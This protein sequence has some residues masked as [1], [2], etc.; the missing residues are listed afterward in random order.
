[1]RPAARNAFL[2]FTTPLEGA[3]PFLYCDVLGLV[4]TAIGVLVDPID[5]ALTL[6][7]RRMP[8]GELA[9]RDEIAADW[10]RVKARTDLSHRGGMVYAQIAQLRLDKDGVRT[11]TDRKLDAMLHRLRLRFDQWDTWPADAQLA[12]VSLS[13]A[14]GPAF[15]FPKLAAHLRTQDWRAAADECVIRPDHGTIKRRNEWMRLCL[16]NAAT[17]YD[18]MADPAVL[19]WPNVAPEG[20]I[21]EPASPQGRD[22]AGGGMLAIAGIVDGL[23]EQERCGSED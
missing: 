14:C 1:M 3:V 2:D 12:V 6:P 7:L 18:S 19:H 22:R 11:V 21:T 8:S 23:R 13:W 10:H 9:S 16:L 5:M 15:G 4:T 20:V 17:V